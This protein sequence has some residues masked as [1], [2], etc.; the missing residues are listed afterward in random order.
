LLADTHGLCPQA[1]G[2]ESTKGACFAHQIGKCKG[3]CAGRESAALH[4]VRLQMALAQQRLQAWPHPGKV[5]VR[6]YQPASGRT[7]IHVFDHWCHVATVQ[8]ASELEDALQSRQALAFDLD[9]YRLLVKRL[10]HPLGRDPSTFHLEASR[11]G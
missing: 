2:L 1:L 6:E 3:L 5:G 7:D 9:T 10:A 11:Y 4:R 8:D